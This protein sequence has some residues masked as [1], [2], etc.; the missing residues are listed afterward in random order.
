MKPNWPSA[1]LGELLD[2]SEEIVVPQL[3]REYREI[4][5]RLWGRG[6]VER[7]RIDGAS[8]AGSRRY[9][10]RAGQF[11]ASRI[12][13]RNG[14]MGIV[15]AGLDGAVVTNDFPLFN[16]RLD[17]LVPSYLGW[18]CRT[19]GFVQL[20]QRASEGTTNRVR[21]QED[22]FLALDIPLPQ[23]AEQ[24]QVVRRI[25]ELSS[26]IN[27]A[28]IL[29]E[30]TEDLSRA[31]LSS[32]RCALIGHVPQEDWVPV[33]QII[34]EIENGRSPQCEPRPAR[35]DEWGVLKVGA[36]SFGSFDE[37]QNK[38]VPVGHPVDERYEVRAGDFLMTR[39]NTSELVGACT[40]VGPTRPKLLL[41]DKI[42]RFHFRPQRGETRKWLEQVMKSPALREQI[43]SGA[44]GTSPTMKNISK[45]KVL[46]LLLPPHSSTKQHRVAT[47]LAALQTEV[48]VVRIA[49]KSTSVE[50]EALLPTILDR[51]FE[52]T[53]G[54]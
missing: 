42:F 20:C 18:L 53:L 52:G 29:R 48:E 21:L 35:D 44:T 43:Q 16:L 9:L 28:R 14:A 27:A 26:Q 38:A 37:R 47:E 32:T 41:S 45:E 40:I 36:V 1:P 13:A 22:R 33:S 19:R 2:R 10:A 50:L 3:E 6:V 5:V 12:D 4:T 15:P 8:L 49:Q 25:E 54:V 46:N 34:S 51:A 24:Q 23:P 17:R 30:K 7:G 31:L 39:A 11:I